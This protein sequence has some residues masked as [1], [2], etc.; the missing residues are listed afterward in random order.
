MAFQASA[1]SP[2]PRSPS[3][4]EVLFQKLEH[5]LERRAGRVA[6]AVDEVVGEDGVRQAREPVGIARRR[7]DLDGLERLADLFPQPGEA[8][9]GTDR[10]FAEAQPEQPRSLL[11][12]LLEARELAGGD[13]E[14]SLGAASRCSSSINPRAKLPV[15]HMPIAPTPGPPQSANAR[16]DSARSQSTTGLDRRAAKIRNS[17]RMHTRREFL[18]VARSPALPKSSGMYTR[19][20]RS[21]IRSASWTH[22]SVMPGRSCISTTAGPSPRQNT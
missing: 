18:T 22:A 5:A 13:G 14:R 11:G 4:L 19:K 7:V 1:S 6:F 21:A 10:V 20:P 9:L 12:P 8:L 17:R 3:V 15:R 2:R 16:R